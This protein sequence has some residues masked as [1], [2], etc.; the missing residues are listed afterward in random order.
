MSSN[1]SLTLHTQIDGAT[2]LPWRCGEA[3]ALLITCSVINFCAEPDNGHGM[4]AVHKN[5][6]SDFPGAIAGPAIA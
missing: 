6:L 4:Y 1:V 2:A 5:D 3:E